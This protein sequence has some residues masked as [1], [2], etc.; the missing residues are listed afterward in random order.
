[1]APMVLIFSSSVQNMKQLYEIVGNL[2]EV[3]LVSSPA[4]STYRHTRHEIGQHFLVGC[5]VALIP[6]DFLV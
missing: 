6:D 4:I 3:T 5:L 2:R 1:M